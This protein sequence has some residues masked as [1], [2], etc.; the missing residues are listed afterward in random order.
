MHTLL[1]TGL[2]EEVEL[3]E[4][5]HIEF[6]GE[7]G[8]GRYLDL[9][10][11]YQRFINSKFGRQTDYAE[12]VS[13]A[14]NFA[15][16]PRSQR[17]SKAYREY[18]GSL[19]RYLESFYQR[20][21]PLGNLQRIEDKVAADFDARFE[22]GS[23]AGWEDRGAGATSA[24]KA[25]QQLDLDAF[26]S[27]EEVSTLGAEK[28]RDAL[29]ALGLK[30]GGTPQQRAERLM[31]TKGVP[32]SSLPKKLFARGAAPSDVQGAEEVQKQ[33]AAAKEAAR[34]EQRL[35]ALCTALGSVLEDTRA[36]VEK[37]QARTYEELKAEQEEQEQAEE[38]SDSDEEMTSSTTPSSCH[39]AGTANP[40]PTGS[41]SCMAST[42]STTA[43]FV[44]TRHTGVVE[45]LRGTSRKLGTRMACAC[46]ASQTTSA[47]TRSPL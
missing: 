12:Y 19:L 34:L 5:P 39:W 11:F 3:K 8:M 26:D 24:S 23:V 41:T 45:R 28:L 10:P 29:A 21:Q 7:E 18:L 32:L 6:S 20:T 40:S 22:A 31:Q 30:S 9:H 42:R 43:R 15:E 36:N 2:D 16:I 27:V 33:K 1:P 14:A 13:L 38:P 25:A 46:W 37:K 17:V 35:L 4:E 47:S 44:E